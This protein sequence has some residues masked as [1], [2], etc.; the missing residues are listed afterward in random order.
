MRSN[1][2]VSTEST[3]QPKRKDKVVKKL[4]DECPDFQD[5][6]KKALQAF[7][8]PEQITVSEFAEK[9][10]VLDNKTSAEPGKWKNSRTPYLVGIMD[11]F[12]DPD[13]EEIIFCK[14]TQVGGTEGLNNIIAYIIAQDPSPTMIVYPT[15]TLAEYTSSNRLQPMIG[16][17]SVLSDRYWANESKM[18]ELQ[19]D[20]M[21]IALS[22]A[23]S[24]SSLASKPI[25]FL[26]MDEID[27]F[28]VMSGK[29]ADPRSLAR[30]RTKTFPYNKKIFQT[31]TPT[32]KHA[33]I[34]SEWE[35]ADQQLKYY[36]PCPH[37]GHKQTFEWAQ[38]KYNAE[39]PEIAQMT[40]RYECIECKKIITDAHKVE[41]VRNG[42]WKAIRKN[43]TRK[44]AFHLNAIYSPWVRFGDVAYE[45]EKSKNEPELFMNFVNSWLAQPWEQT[46]VKMNTD[47]VLEKQSEY[48]EGVIP[49]GTL[50]VTG[51]VDVQKDHFYWTIRAW[52]KHMTSWNISHGCCQSYSEL[53]EIMNQAF[54]GS[55]GQSYQVNLCAIDSGFNTD[56]IYEF[57]AMNSDWLIPAKGS[58]RPLVK[59]YSE[60]VIDKKD[61]TAD[62]MTLYLCDGAQYKDMISSRLQK[63]IGPGCWMVYKDCDRDYANQICA[64]EKVKIQKSGRTIEEWRKKDKEENHYLDAEVYAA[65]AA[66]LMRVR[67]LDGPEPETEQPKPQEVQPEIQQ[68]N[69]IK[70]M[71]GWLR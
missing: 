61:C 21:Y 8:P 2:S 5:W 27:K 12:N 29:E 24:P 3:K 41:M 63:P 4:L 68:S 10:R 70:P 60:S 25:R 32:Y 16:L 62:G 33:P 1:K 30:E 20:S 18:L 38:I 23:N 58:S 37:C 44:T 52:G 6:L 53:E 31:S 9:H 7:K 19:F 67:Y 51:G 45:Y 65:M 26:L 42:E 56:E 15:D 22:G 55:N 13:I 49:E 11:A 39:S 69:W 14:P 34:W 50:L 47:V 17:C 54:L 48:P 66:D 46:E 36:V 57:C 28:P 40:A 43:G 71:G 64:E 59:R 35:K